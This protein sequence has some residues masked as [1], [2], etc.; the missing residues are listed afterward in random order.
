MVNEIRE[1]IRL[2]EKEMDMAE[3]RGDMRLYLRFSTEQLNLQAQLKILEEISN[4]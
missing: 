4:E 1:T 3:S 2:I